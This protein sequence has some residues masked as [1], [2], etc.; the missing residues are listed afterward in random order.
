MGGQNR[1][2]TKKK[3]FFRRKQSECVSLN[4]FLGSLAPAVGFLAQ[5]EVGPDFRVWPKIAL[6]GFFGRFWIKIK[7]NLKSFPEITRKAMNL[8]F[9]FNEAQWK[10]FPRENKKKNKSWHF[11]GPSWA[12][13]C[14]LHWEN[15]SE[16]PKSGKMKQNLK[17]TTELT[18]KA[19]KLIFFLNEAQ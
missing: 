5:V 18:R 8:I 9:F 11:W 12:C 1:P 14:G 13:G 2:K 10:C 6:G 3:F 4:F 19:M 16:R 7:Q 17:S 15:G